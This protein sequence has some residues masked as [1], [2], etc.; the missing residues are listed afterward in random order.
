MC[1]A[2]ICRCH[3]KPEAILKLEVSKTYL[4]AEGSRVKIIS[5]SSALPD[6]FVGEVLVP[7]LSCG[8]AIGNTGQ[9]DI[10]GNRSKGSSVWKLVSEYKEPEYFYVNIYGMEKGERWAATYSSKE[11]ADV[12]ACRYKSRTVCIRI[13]KE[14]KV[15]EKLS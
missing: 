13:N 3:C 4:T 9:W 8:V 15:V 10:Y 11:E 12:N 2:P 7:S 1:E 14:T 5:K 6:S